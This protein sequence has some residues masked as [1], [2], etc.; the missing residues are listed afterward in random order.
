MGNRLKYFIKVNKWPTSIF[1]HLRDLYS[2]HNKVTFHSVQRTKNGRDWQSWWACE[3]TRTLVCW[4]LERVNDTTTLESC[5]VVFT[6][7][8]RNLRFNPASVFLGIY[9]REVATRWSVNVYVNFIYNYPKLETTQIFISK[10]LDKLWS[11]HRWQRTQ[12]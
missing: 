1:S 4:W 7:L 9:R 3:A 11:I 8:N 10:H 2:N 12:S 5:L 6:I